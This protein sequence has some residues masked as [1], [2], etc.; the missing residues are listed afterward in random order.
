MLINFLPHSNNTPSNN[1]PLPLPL[2]SNLVDHVSLR[3]RPLIKELKFAFDFAHPLDGW[4][5]IVL[6]L[7]NQLQNL[8][9]LTSVDVT[10]S[11][12]EMV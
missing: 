7:L 10:V 2:C 1:T 5:S 4:D 6:R 11:R 12:Q 8:T 9:M 3:V